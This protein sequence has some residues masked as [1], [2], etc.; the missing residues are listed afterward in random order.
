LPRLEPGFHLLQHRRHDVT[1]V[2]ADQDSWAAGDRVIAPRRATRQERRRLLAGAVPHRDVVA[3][4]EQSLGEHRA[5]QA[6]ADHS[7]VLQ[8]RSLDHAAR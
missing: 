8:F 7:D 3:V 5:H 6:E 2:K 4:I 1:G